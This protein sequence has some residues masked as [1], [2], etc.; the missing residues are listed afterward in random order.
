M[1]GGKPNDDTIVYQNLVVGQGQAQPDGGG[2]FEGVLAQTDT[3]RGG[4]IVPNGLDYYVGIQ[5][6]V[7]NTRLPLL[8]GEMVILSTDGVELAYSL[9]IAGTVSGNPVL[10]RQPLRLQIPLADRMMWAS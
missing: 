6:L 3:Q 4:V 1:L 10:T 5:R 9:T 8:L 7:L 2:A